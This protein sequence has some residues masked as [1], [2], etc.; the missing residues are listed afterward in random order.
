MLMVGDKGER[1]NLRRK[2]KNDLIITTFQLVK[3]K[4]VKMNFFNSSND[5]QIGDSLLK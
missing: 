5:L 1:C 2:C 3:L 4:D